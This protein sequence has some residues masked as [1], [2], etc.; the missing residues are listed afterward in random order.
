MIYSK[1]GSLKSILL[2]SKGIHMTAYI[3]NTSDLADTRLQII[4]SIQVA[5]EYLTPVQSSD[6]IEAF[7]EPV[8]KLLDNTS[9]LK[10]FNDN[11]G[12]FRSSNSFRVINLPISLEHMCVIADSYH[13]KPLL[14][15]VQSDQD[16]FILGISNKLASLYQGSKTSIRLIDSIEFN[17]LKNQ[18]MTTSLK[19]EA[20]YEWINELLFSL[21][22]Q[23]S[24]PLYLAGDKKITDSL[25]KKIK[26]PLTCRKSLFSNFD[27][28]ILPDIIASARNSIEDDAKRKLDTAFIEFYLAED[29]KLAQKNLFQISKAAVKG[30]IKKLI[31]ADGVQI[32]G[33]IDRVTGGLLIHPTDLDHEDDDIL[34]DLAQTVLA[35]GGDVIVADHSKIPKGRMILAILKDGEESPAKEISLHFNNF[36]E[37][38]V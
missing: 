9:L 38:T 31:V 6:E 29:S 8:Y 25:F 20:I 1:L 3:K 7:L 32:F 26:Y 11:I 23:V 27:E 10:H 5:K 16:F 14:K 4:D 21:T 19:T 30:R 17:Q 13:I 15:W 33:K 28:D 37:A 2:S 34:D 35:N 22:K 24:I 12:I 18:K 36:Y